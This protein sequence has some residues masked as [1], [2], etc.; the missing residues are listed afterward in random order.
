MTDST[1]TP[2]VTPQQGDPW[3]ADAAARGQV[4][5]QRVISAEVV[6]PSPDVQR[7]LELE[8][9][10]LV[11]VRRRLIL[12][13][14]RPV[15]LADSYY[16]ATIAAGTPLADTKRIKGGAVRYLHEIG[17]PPED[18]TEEIAA[19]LPTTAEAELL[20]VTAT[21]ALL[22]LMRVSRPTGRDPVE[23]DV[24]LMVPGKASPLVYRIRTVA[25]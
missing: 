12:A 7:A 15:E 22:V 9:G 10:E 24:N 3:A 19:R 8:P 11:V 17:L 4:G 5:S 23:Y 20:A 21:T 18:V 6:Q 25:P 14:D 16:P 2:Y 13:D 1:S